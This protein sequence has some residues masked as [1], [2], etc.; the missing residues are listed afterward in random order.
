M[1]TRTRSPVL[2]SAP[3]S[4]ALASDAE[5]RRE[6]RFYVALGALTLLFASLPYLW[7]YA[8][9]P[10]G[11]VYTGFF[12]NNI[13]D[14][15]VYLAWMR[16]AEAGHFFLR[17]QFTTEPQRGVVFNLF[18][19]LLGT[20][21]RVTGLP[22]IAVYHGARIAAG[23]LLLWAVTALLRATLR[24]ARARQTAF[25]LVCVAAG[26]G[27]AWSGQA[28][29]R[30]TDQPVDL[31]QPEAI[32]FL[33]LYANPLFPAAIALMAVFFAAMLRAERTGRARDLWPAAVAGALLGNFHSYDVI[34]LFAAWGAY[35]LVSDLGARRVDTG[36]WARLL[37]VG[38]ATLPTVAYQF[39]ALRV[40]TV[41]FQRAFTTF[42]RSAS[43]GWVL[44]GLGLPALLAL[45]ALALA[46]LRPR[47]AERARLARL[48]TDAASFR[49]LLTWAVA[50][51]AVAYLPLP[52]QRK[53]L[54]GAHLPLCL[55]AGAVLAQWAARLPGDLPR[56]ALAGAVLFTT[57]TNVWFLARD[58]SHLAQNASATSHRP[59]LTAGER[60]ALRWLRDNTGPRDAVLVAPDPTSH[61]RFPFFPLRPHL[62][63][64]VPALAGNVVYNGHWSETARYGEK[65]AAATEFFRA[66]TP[67]A[68]RIGLLR[69]AGIRYVL[70]V[71]A[72]G[73]A[74]LRDEKGAVVYAP[75]PW[76]ASAPPYLRPV[77]RNREITIYRVDLPS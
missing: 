54:M 58:M 77:F 60:E 19:W 27:W 67:D 62:A 37:A 31:W 48:F 36:G 70:H 9:T 53:L 51:V 4:G 71:N 57:P 14:A 44:L 1:A 40:E 73:T 69:A 41:F 28:P 45:W 5:G 16:Q 35:R 11:Q 72:L 68:F 17:N 33:S 32:A 39:W 29:A 75:A 15:G 34:P 12:V 61:Q 13:D 23:A 3:T 49:L 18:F 43:P 76:P 24:E 66:G 26:F 47:G 55:L 7:G 2:P 20:A 22:P 64:Y 8:V 38:L 10:P 46:L 6:R 50:G 30:G 25:A 21:A 63:A 52:F 74:S 65:L 59:R 56:I 42:T